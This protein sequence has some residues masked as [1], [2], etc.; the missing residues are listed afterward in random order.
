MGT[1]DTLME[2]SRNYIGNKYNDNV[3]NKLMVEH[4]INYRGRDTYECVFFIKSE[5][6]K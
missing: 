1:R 4:S 3:W 2:Y 5:S 6:E